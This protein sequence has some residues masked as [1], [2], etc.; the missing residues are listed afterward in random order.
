MPSVDANGAG[1]NRPAKNL[2]TAK[3]PAAELP[4]ELR[5]L[6]K[7]YE[8]THPDF[9]IEPVSYLVSGPSG[10]T[11]MKLAPSE[12]PHEDELVVLSV[13]ETI[14]SAKQIEARSHVLVARQKPAE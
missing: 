6:L 8:E 5:R 13:T 9:R 7:Q 2:V 1:R 3:L 14:A 10:E 12:L 4:G 11:A